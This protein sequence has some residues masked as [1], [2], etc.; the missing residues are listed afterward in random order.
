MEKKEPRFLSVHPLQARI[1][2]FYTN[3]KFF[4]NNKINQIVVSFT[5][6][7]DPISLDMLPSRNKRSKD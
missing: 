4:N 5:D 2:R 3:V 6:H 1:D 7:Y